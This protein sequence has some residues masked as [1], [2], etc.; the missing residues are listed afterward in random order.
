V[1]TETISLWPPIK[2]WELNVGYGVSS[3]IAAGGRVCAMGHRKGHDTVFC[4]DAETGRVIW[5]YSYAARSDQTSDVR[6]QGP[7]STP[8]TDGA[9]VYTLS[10]EGQ[11]H[12]FDAAS[13]GVLWSKSPVE[14]GASEKQQYGVCCAPLV[15]ED[16]LI[17]DV[18]TRCVALDKTTGRQL[19]QTAG[20]GGWNGAAPVIARLGHKTCVIHGTGRCL[21][22]VDGRELWHVPYGEWS[23]ATPIVWEDKVFLSP[24]HGRNLGGHGC[25]VVQVKDGQPSVLWNTDEMEGLCLT[26]V[27]WKGY[28]YAPDRDDLSI[29]GESGRKMNLK[30]ID[31]HTGEV[32]WV[33][34]PIPWPTPIVVGGKLLIQTLRGELILA[35]ASP[36]GYREYG[37]A[38]GA[39][40][41]C[42]TVPAVADG[43]LFCRNNRGDLVCFQI[44]GERPKP[45]HLAAS[46]IAPSEPASAERAET[47]SAVRPTAETTTAEAPAQT[48]ANWPRFRGPRGSGF[49]AGVCVPVL[50]NGKTGEGIVWKAEVPLPGYS[51][52]VVWSDRV[53][54]TGANKQ[55]REVYCY[56]SAS[57]KLLWRRAVSDGSESPPGP[58]KAR[59]K[60]SY[61]APTPVVDAECVW[62]MFAGGDIVSIDHDGHLRW[63][64]H[65]GRPN[66]QY[67]HA[68]SIVKHRSLLI[69]QIDQGTNEENKSRLLGLDAGSGRTIWET[70]RPVGASWSTP[71]VINHAGRNQIVASG[72]PWVIAYDAGS[73]AELWR[74]D[75]LEDGYFAVPSPTYAAGML[76]AVTEGAVLAA[77]RPDGNGD[78]SRTHIVWTAEEDLPDICSPV[79]N[80]DQVFLLTTDGLLTA[81]DVTDGMQVWHKDFSDAG[82]SFEASPLIVGGHLYLLDDSGTMVIVPATREPQNSITAELGEACLGASPAFAGERMYIRT[83]KHL[84]RIDGEPS[85]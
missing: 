51:S 18:G 7:R 41:R 53:F 30:C 23:V 66:N 75:C 45:E 29:A 44:S 68:S 67:G 83:W 39:S 52:P 12:C 35:D 70:K 11:L 62:A 49:S 74:A 3:V 84:V 73:G 43:R 50:F 82:W 8:A 34:R 2:R 25:A 22:L 15:Y 60:A 58:G 63:R 59:N 54:L 77:I 80:G 32:K 71:I 42:W 78:V 13:G 10:L 48:A 17:C 65:L 61:A 27:L 16:T 14:M 38:Q 5:K 47:S 46:K 9:A 56:S 85:R 72:I 40:G 36:E 37:R 19:W 21:D 1:S 79:S 4:L 57:G 31:F 64:R 6:F 76:F 24:F 20:G 26:A 33:H 55:S 81:H 28:L 69:V